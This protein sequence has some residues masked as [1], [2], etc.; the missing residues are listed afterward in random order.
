[1]SLCN[2]AFG[3]QDTLKYWIQFT[4]KAN[5]P[6]DVAQPLAF[7]SPRAIERRQHQNIAISVQDFPVNPDYIDSLTQFANLSVHNTSRWMNAVT[8]SC[9]DTLELAQI[10]SFP[11][12]NKIE[13]VQRLHRPDQY[14]EKFSNEI[15]I[16]RSGSL[17][18]ST[19]S[20]YPYGL[21]Y[22]QN[23]L[24]RIDYLH[25][26]G[27]NGQGVHI[28]VIDSGFE[29]AHE[30][31]CF[32]HVFEEGRVLSTKDFVDHDG[33]VFW[34]HY[35][36]TAVWS[37]M[38]AV[39]EGVYYGTATKASYHLL[40][41]EAADY[42]HL[43]EEDNWIAAAEYADSAGVDI[44]NTSLG[45]ATFDDSTQNH[46]FADMDG[47]TTRIAIAAD[48][49]AAKGIL[50]VTSAGNMGGGDWQYITTPAD[51]DSTITVGAVD[52][53]G[54]YAFFSS[55]GPSSDGDVKPNVASVGWNT[56]LILPWGETIVRGNGTS[57]SSPMIAGMAACLWQSLPHFSAQEIKTLIEV[58]AHQ[59]HQPDSLMGYGIP[60]FYAAYRSITGLNYKIDEGIAVLSVYP[61][62]FNTEL[63]LLIRSDRDQA[64]QLSGT[65]LMGQDLFSYTTTLKRG[66]NQLFLH[67]F[68]WPTGIIFLTLTDE[69]GVRTTLKLIRD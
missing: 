50:L 19:N 41:S 57:F 30:M 52:S 69:L 51:A 4:D 36:G 58:S 59:Y 40:R 1:M 17:T 63:T 21:C 49:A 67:D 20:N 68:Q 60:D 53:L 54:N 23:H 33:D 8:V 18:V 11:F 31:D 24:H 9:W 32:R 13:V 39:V 62:P 34:D 64:I 66:K 3:Q 14:I 35:H 61:N 5:S 48:I 55:T 12:V 15:P 65:N 29:Y 45:Y 46:T 25:D 6:F 27:F 7:L 16:Q 44:L 42:E 47:N 26:L 38:A 22:H 28:G 56:Y 43:V 37:V 2:W 10:L